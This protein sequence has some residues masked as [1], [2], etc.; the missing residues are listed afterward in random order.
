[1][2]GLQLRL[3]AVALA[4]CYSP[5]N[6]ADCELSCSAN[7]C[8]GGFRCDTAIGLC[9]A[10]GATGACHPAD[11]GLPIDT[12][13]GPAGCWNGFAPTNYDPCV[14]L[15]FPPLEND[16]MIMTG[17]VIDTDARTITLVAGG[18]TSPLGVGYLFG[19]APEVTMVHV[20][21]FVVGPTAK[22]TVVGAHPLLIA[23]EDNIE[24]DGRL[25]GT[26]ANGGD[27]DC[28][29]VPT[30]NNE[31]I[32]PGGEGGGYGTAGG[33]GGDGFNG[34][35]VTGP[36]GMVANGTPTISPLRGG[37]G[38]GAGGD[39]TGSTGGAAGLAGGG[40]ELSSATIVTTSGTIYSDGGGGGIG[41]IF[42]TGSS[43]SGGGGSGGAILIEAPTVVFAGNPEV[44]AVGGGGAGGAENVPPGPATAGSGCTP[45]IGGRS[46]TTSMSAGG[47]GGTT[48][49][50]RD[51]D[52][53]LGMIGATGG[54]GG[55]GRIRIRSNAQTGNALVVPPAT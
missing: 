50:G 41:E 4:G 15:T 47:D 11:A 18:G 55:A 25:D 28:P 1:M 37:C 27:H 5:K 52:V 35:Q 32:G 6:V 29:I 9:R 14:T 17:A 23:A 34:N 30:D 2:G 19:G 33:N 22:V 44:C 46:M 12:P 16:V 31:Q 21:I 49:P 42:M 26:T 43:G 53:S 3:A 39:G 38:G 36:A 24:I 20:N 7:D 51:G 13:D 45:G 8:P 10:A 48:G 40:I 54:G